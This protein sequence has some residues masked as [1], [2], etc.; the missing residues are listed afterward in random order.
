MSI[1]RR[2]FLSTAA[3]LGSGIFVSESLL[4]REL[5][6]GTSNMLALEN[7]M[8]RNMFTYVG[9]RTTKERNARGEGIS[10]F[11]MDPNSGHWTHVQLVRDLVNPSFFVID[12]RKQFLYCVHGDSTEISAFAIDRQTGQLTFVN[13][14]S[15]QGRNP[16]HLAVDG[17]NR[18]VLVA[19]YATGTLAVVP[20]DS[21]GSLGEVTQL[22]ELTGKPGPYSRVEQVSSHPH[23]IPFDPAGKFVVVPDKGLDRVFMFRFD[24]GAGKLSPAETGSLELRP[25]SAPRHIAF[26]PTAKYAYVIDEL[27]STVTSYRY[28]AG[29]GHLDPFQVIPSVPDTFVGNNA[30]SEIAV[31]P[32]GKFVYGSNRGH[33]SIGIFAVDPTNGRLSPVGWESS[34]GKGP[35]FFALDPSGKFLYA[36][37]ELSDTIVTFRVNQDT[38]KLSPT[39]QVVNTGT[40][41]CIVFLV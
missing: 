37:N 12:H 40:P 8:N 9:C 11:Q 27:D 16:V 33:D 14:R 35:R 24:A 6:R 38:G 4:A 1:T 3:A 13:K 23:D 19:N 10:V 32:S 28:D 15:T 18:F 31:A 39:G 22:V 25:G 36:A 21:D 34:Q 2:S 26:H 5:N 29:R 41:V 30:G 17:S 20:I 7:S